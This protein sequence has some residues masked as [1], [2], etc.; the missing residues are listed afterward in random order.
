MSAK[1]FVQ[2]EINGDPRVSTESAAVMAVVLR[3]IRLVF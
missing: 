3:D 1:G 2:L